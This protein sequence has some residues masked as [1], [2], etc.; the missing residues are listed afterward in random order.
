M[1]T[2][3]FHPPSAV[4]KRPVRDIIPPLESGDRLTRAEFER[5][6]EAM[7]HLKKAEL[8]EG[9]VVVASPVSALHSEPHSDVM[10]WLW[11]YAAATPQVEV[12]DN[13]SLR[14]DP[15]NEVQPD[16]LL[17]LKPEYGGTMRR[18]DDGYLEGAPDL[19]VEVAVSSASHDL[20]DKLHVYRRNGV[21]EYV[22]WQV[23]DGRL[24]W[25]RLEAGQY[26][27]LVADEDGIVRSQRFPGLWLAGEALLTGDKATVFRAIQA[28]VTSG[29][30][31]AFVA[32][33][34]EQKANVARGEA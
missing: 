18:S 1:N 13:A 7:P 20:Y 33:V 9:K 17:A 10:G 23:L 31:G 4:V 21:Q 5:R 22:V 2:L 27:S 25:W 28:G 14:L 15:D 34:E 32:R 12:H 26:V 24:S 3:A 11:V 8:V 6:Y 30:H 29:T 16:A 19:V